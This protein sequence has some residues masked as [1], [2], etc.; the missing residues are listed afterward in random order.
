MRVKDL[1]RIIEGLDDDM[2][3]LTC[4]RGTSGV[5]KSVWARVGDGAAS[6]YGYVLPVEAGYDLDG[7]VEPVLWVG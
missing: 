1:R 5:S 3:V 4:P 2:E 6:R 7:Q